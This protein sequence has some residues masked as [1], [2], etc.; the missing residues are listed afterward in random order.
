MNKNI[1]WKLITILAVV[2]SSLRSASTR[3]SRSRYHM[4]LPS[5]LM[6]KQL[7]WASTCAAACISSPRAHRRR[8]RIRIDDDGEQLREALKTASVSVNVHH[9]A[10]PR[11]SG[12]RAS[13]RNGRG[14]SHG[15]PT[16]R[17]DDRVRSQFG[18]GRELRFHDETEHRARR[19]REQ[20]VTQARKRSI[21]ASTS[22]ASPNRTFRSTGNRTTRSSSSC[23]A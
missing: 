14:A 10:S 15:S 5:W 21:G 6:A 4:P 23:Q 18:C 2:V 22:S 3:S 19:M 11:R 7:S 12:S 20:A 1:R 9:R 16:I 17:A 13:R 8:A